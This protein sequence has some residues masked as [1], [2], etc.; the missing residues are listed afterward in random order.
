MVNP[1]MKERDL[2]GGCLSNCSN[3]SSLGNG[4]WTFLMKEEYCFRS[5][6]I[7]RLT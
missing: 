1:L 4:S 6:D 5:G 3:L 7:S 2:A